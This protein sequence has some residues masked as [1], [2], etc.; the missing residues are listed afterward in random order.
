MT[1]S[2]NKS[3]DYAIIIDSDRLKSLVDIIKSGFEDIFYEIK[4]VD[5]A[6]YRMNAIEDVISY[7]NPSSRRI[8]KIVISANKQSETRKLFPDFSIAL[9]DSSQYSASCILSLNNMNEQEIA[10]WSQRIEEFV[11]SSRAS[12][13]WVHK[14]VVYWAIG[15]LLYFA[16]I[17]WYH[18]KMETEGLTNGLSTLSLVSISVICFYISWRLIKKCVEYLFP[19][20]GFVIGEQIRVLQRREKV[21]SIVLISVVV[22]LVIGV[23]SG[24]IVN[25][26]VS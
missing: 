5:G 10:Y 4:T 25:C 24:I 23:I 26:I 19:E 21:R 12:Y 9:F 8:E 3:F 16:F 13:W 17:V 15:M 6:S 22:S 7:N 11:S 1:G 18:A 2:L 20:G 14:P